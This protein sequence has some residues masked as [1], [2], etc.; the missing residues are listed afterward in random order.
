MEWL[1][2]EL[3]LRLVVWLEAL[4][5]RSLWFERHLL[6]LVLV[7]DA[8][9][10]GV[11]GRVLGETGPIGVLGLLVQTVHFAGAVEDRWVRFL[12]F[13]ED[14]LAVLELHQRW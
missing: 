11:A 3:V 2:S 1:D 12:K 6:L 7:L 10:A 9:V 5:V 13:L 14:F 8:A 4:V